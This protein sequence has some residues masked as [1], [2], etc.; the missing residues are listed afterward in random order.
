M[1]VDT[2]GGFV[3]CFFSSRRRHTSCALVTGVETCALPI[4]CTRDVGGADGRSIASA[5]VGLGHA[6]GLTVIAEGVETGDEAAALREL[7]YDEFQGFHFAAPMPL[8][9]YRTWIC[10]Q[11]ALGLA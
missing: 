5:I 9:Q 7:G 2:R 11:Q 10:E 8:S 4:C 3:V 6:L 1:S